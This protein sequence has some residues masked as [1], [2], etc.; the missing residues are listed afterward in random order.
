MRGEEIRDA[1]AL[2]GSVLGGGVGL[3]EELHRA[4]ADRS[5][6]AA[7]QGAHANRERHDRI[8]LAGY[9]TVAALLRTAPRVLAAIGA[10]VIPKVDSQPLDA[11]LTGNAALGA[12][13]G[14]WGDR[15]ADAGNAFAVGMSVRHDRA[16]LVLTVDSVAAAFP[17]P[18]SR[19]AVFVHGLCETD[20]S[21][22]PSDRKRRSVGAFDF[23]ERLGT[24][25][26][27]TPV[28][29]RYN[30]G[31]HVSDNGAAL[32]RL[33]DELSAV[34]P[35]AVTEVALLG[36]SMGGL[37]VR[38]ACHQADERGA[39]WV[40]RVRHVVCLGT[41]HLGAPLEKGT[42]ALSWV[43][44]RV[45]ET[46]G[47]ARVLNARS[48]GVKDL[49]YGSLVEADW[50]GVDLDEFLTDRCNEVPFLPYAGYYFVGV[51]V[52]QDRRHPVGMLVGDLLVQLPSASGK[53]RRRE[54]P[55]DLDKGRHI[56]GLT[57]FDLLSHPDVYAQV[58][59]WLAPTVAR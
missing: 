57:H 54:I 39:Q 34:W 10:V 41:P 27:Y 5:F 25:T 43:L 38:S 12:M 6:A 26:D 22:R 23:G 51:T 11:T 15:L 56:G 4:I 2:A 18:T 24:D 19:L 31:L 59:H 28:Y 46:R 7:G 50:E 48:V 16:D 9:G 45:P 13:N 17:H 55:F 14:L 52:T 30:S 36:H 47:L 3:V 35:V 58:E 53:G 20:D 33:L 42:N 32:D 1:G 29:V 40:R 49:R 44:D 37:V 21:W 8:A